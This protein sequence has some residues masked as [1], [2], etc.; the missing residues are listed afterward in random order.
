METLSFQT[1]YFNGAL[2][3]SGLIVSLGPQNVMAIRHGISGSYAVTLA[4]LFIAADAGLIVLGVILASSGAS[5]TGEGLPTTLTF[6]AVA[7][8]SWL[9]LNSLSSA[10]ARGEQRRTEVSEQHNQLGKVMLAGAAVTFLN[11]GVYIDTL[12]LIGVVAVKHQPQQWAL[13]LGAISTSLL[14]FLAIALC[15]RI[16]RPFFQSDA[17]WRTLDLLAGIVMLSV[18]WQIFSL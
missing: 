9:A 14:W 12:G 6:V 16:C 8:L 10:A 15:G 3:M 1:A 2:L 18:A 17:S 11:P 7:Y 13:A 5:F 4:A